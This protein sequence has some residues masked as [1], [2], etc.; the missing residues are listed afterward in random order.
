MLH[1]LFSCKAYA[2]FRNDVS[3]FIVSHT[4]AVADVSYVTSA[5]D[6]RTIWK[7]SRFCITLCKGKTTL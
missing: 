4:A 3:L 2:D 5:V 6:D 7:M 1:V